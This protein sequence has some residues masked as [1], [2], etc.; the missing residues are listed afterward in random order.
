MNTL[1]NMMSCV[2]GNYFFKISTVELYKQNVEYV[3]GIRLLLI[4]GS[5]FFMDHSKKYNYPRITFC[6]GKIF[7]N[8]KYL[9]IISNKKDNNTKQFIGF[10]NAYSLSPISQHNEISKLISKINMENKRNKC[11][12]YN[13]AFFDILCNYF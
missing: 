12:T 4:T 11:N 1:I 6:C 10:R 3:S 13:K 8:D 9:G 5:Q 2:L 7:S